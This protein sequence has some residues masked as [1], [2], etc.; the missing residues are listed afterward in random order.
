[1]RI[2]VTH[3]SI[4]LLVVAIYLGNAWMRHVSPSDLKVPMILSFVAILM[5]LVSSWFGGKMVFE[6]GVGVDTTPR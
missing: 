6:H 1:M 5:L 4:N 3:M 2:A